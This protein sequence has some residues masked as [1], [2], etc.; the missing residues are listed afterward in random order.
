[1]IAH[2]WNFKIRNIN[3]FNSIWENSR[4]CFAKNSV[5]IDLIYIW[6]KVV[7]RHFW[8]SD[9]NLLN[10]IHVSLAT[11]ELVSHQFWMDIEHMNHNLQ[12][13]VKTQQKSLIS[14]LF[15]INY[16]IRSEA[17]KIHA[18]GKSMS[19]MVGSVAI[20][21]EYRSTWTM[22]LTPQTERFMMM[23]DQII[24]RRNYWW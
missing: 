15:T 8:W 23:L 2:K 24:I 18:Q 9:Q 21:L 17:K 6:I 12:I 22:D 11:W 10:N 1:M 3:I 19:W 14:Q 13:I 4:L 5:E 20:N 16:I 7:V